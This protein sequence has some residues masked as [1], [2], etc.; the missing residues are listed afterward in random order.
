MVQE[1][2]RKLKFLHDLD[3]GYK[4]LHKNFEVST[5][6]GG[7]FPAPYSKVPKLEAVHLHTLTYSIFFAVFSTYRK[8]KK[9]SFGEVVISTI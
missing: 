2:D 6:F 5:I 4:N 7:R 8:D 1:A 3:T 9:I